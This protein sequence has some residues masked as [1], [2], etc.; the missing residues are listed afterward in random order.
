MRKSYKKGGATPFPLSYFSKSYIEP[1][2]SAGRNLL[3]SIAP[4]GVRPKIGGQRSSRKQK[5][6]TR[7]QKQSGGFVPTVMEGF[8]TA[9]AKYITPIAL[10]AGYKLL[11]RK[12]KRGSRRR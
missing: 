4:I 5:K 11:T 3:E 10:F 6:S 8:V 2:A 1:S 12:Q 9:A 7:K